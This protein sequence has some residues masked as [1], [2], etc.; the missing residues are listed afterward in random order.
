MTALASLD[1]WAFYGSFKTKENHL[2][3]FGNPGLCTFRLSFNRKALA[4]LR[5]PF[6]IADLE[7]CGTKSVPSIA[8][9]TAFSCG[10]HRTTTTSAAPQFHAHITTTKFNTWGSLDRSSSLLT[11]T[12]PFVSSVPI[13]GDL[14]EVGNAHTFSMRKEPKIAYW[15]KYLTVFSAFA[16]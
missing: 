9:R 11:K 4:T 14:H 8:L 6:M 7:S 2:R 13:F 3:L 12:I 1:P 5:P 15:C 10:N 16:P